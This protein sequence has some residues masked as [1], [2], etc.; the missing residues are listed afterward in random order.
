MGTAESKDGDDYVEGGLF[1]VEEQIVIKQVHKEIS[2]SED[3]F[4]NHLKL[5]DNKLSENLLKY[6]SSLASR[7]HKGVLFTYRQFHMLLSQLFRGSSTDKASALK[8]LCSQSKEISSEDLFQAVLQ[9]V[10]AYRKVTKHLPLWSKWKL[11]QET[12]QHQKEFTFGL[13]QELFNKGLSKKGPVP[14]AK[15]PADV[16]YTEADVEDLLHKSPLFLQVCDA[17]FMTLF[18]ISNDENSRTERLCSF[19]PIPIT[20]VPNKSILDPYAMKFLNFNLPKDLQTEWRLV[21][22]NSVFGDSFTQLVSHMLNKG[23]SLLIVKDKTGHV[24]GGYASEKWQLNSKFYGSS[25][26]FL[27]T[28]SPQYGIYNTTTY[29]SN[30]MYLNQGQQTLPN[31]LGMGGQFDY[32]GLW[33]DQSFNYGHSKAQPRCTTYAS[34]QLSGTPEFEVVA[35]EVWEVGPEPKA[36]SDDEE[37]KE[38]KKSILDGNSEAKAMLSLIG[39]ERVSEGYRDEDDDM[40]IS[41]DMKRKMNTIPS[42]I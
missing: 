21:F 9:L 18:P 41:E 2:V 36:D 14:E 3:L 28:L 23:P 4:K 13:L 20:M 29:N 16:T 42:L 10:K 15:I 1:S 12:D 32:F 26:N 11:D 35:L 37:D 6:L 5:L 40:E 8:G 38:V 24:F 17:V 39:K 25:D 33:I 31:G 22:S 7:P 19:V 34:P 30:Y 27:F